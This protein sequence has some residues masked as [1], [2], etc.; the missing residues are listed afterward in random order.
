M[1]ER[2]RRRA[3]LQRLAAG[4]PVT[5]MDFDPVFVTVARAAIAGVLGLALLLVFREKRPAR[6]DLVSLAIVRSVS[7]WVS[8]C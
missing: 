2:I 4:Y 3:D 6:S 7:L 5:V 1:D 8:R